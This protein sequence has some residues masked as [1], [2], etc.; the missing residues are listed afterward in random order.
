M[1]LILSLFVNV[2][3]VLSVRFQTGWF[4]FHHLFDFIDPIEDQN[5]PRSYQPWIINFKI[6]GFRRGSSKFEMLL[7]YA[8]HQPVLILVVRALSFCCRS[9][10]NVIARVLNLAFLCSFTF[11]PEYLTSHSPLRRMS[12]AR[13]FIAQIKSPSSL[14]R[15]EPC[16]AR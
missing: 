16:K 7:G 9:P 6:I 10:D 3:S 14:A 1:P 2:F 4:I 12:C 11:G 8:T 5:W 13:L 15:V